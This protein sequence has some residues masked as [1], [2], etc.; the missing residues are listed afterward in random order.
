MFGPEFQE[1]YERVRDKFENGIN[2]V[3]AAVDDC[4]WLLKVIT[5]SLVII[6]ASLVFIAAGSVG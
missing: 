6:A 1:D 5:G 3:A 2:G 4:R